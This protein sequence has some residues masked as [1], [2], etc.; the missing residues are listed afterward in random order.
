MAYL[1]ACAV[2]ETVPDAG[3]AAGTDMNQL[4]IAAVRHQLTA[5]TAMALESAGVKSDAFTQAKGKAIRKNA[6]L[7]L[8]RAALSERLEAAGIWYMPLKGAVLAGYYPQF[9][10]RQM[11]DNDILFDPARADD[12]KEIM[13]SLG[14]AVDSFGEEAHDVYIKPPVSTFEMHRALFDPD[15]DGKLYDY[16]RDISSRLTVEEGRCARRF[17]DEDFYV[18][19][20]AHEYKHFTGSGTG[21]RSLLDTYVFW[22]WFG[23]RLDTDYIA[24]ELTKLGIAAFEEQTRTLAMRLFNEEPL[25]QPEETLLRYFITCGVYGTNESRAVNRI[26]KQGRWHYL[27]TRVFLPYSL[28]TT[29][30]PILKPL[31]VLLP[32]CWMMRLVKGFLHSRKL[33]RTQLKA[34]LHYKKT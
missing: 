3:R 25:S 24:A 20:T 31:P 7:D 16:Y 5:I 6:V 1:A 27:L 29:L 14:F 34:V 19:L 28:M 23:G 32:V 10:M 21:L 15:R 17:R 9:G 33:I 4:Y 26:K 2:K 30:Y 22:Q 11:S 8:D 18:Y 13:L 12:V